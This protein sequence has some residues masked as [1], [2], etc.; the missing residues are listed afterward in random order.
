MRGNCKQCCC[1]LLGV[2]SVYDSVRGA[3]SESNAESRALLLRF[4]S[5]RTAPQRQFS[6]RSIW[7]TSRRSREEQSREQR[8][9]SPTIVPAVDKVE[10][11]SRPVSYV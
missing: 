10:Q 8:A 1:A 3:A 11:T 9:D 7:Y 6:Y 4:R 5:T 2:P